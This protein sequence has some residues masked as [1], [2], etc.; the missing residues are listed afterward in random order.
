MQAGFD[1][2]R[3]KPTSD[4]ASSNRPRATPGLV[5]RF[6]AGHEV[7]T[8]PASSSLETDAA[9]SLKCAVVL[10]AA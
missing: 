5:A 9:N 7:E 2:H 1:H 6:V 3:V 4:S 10:V 8:Q